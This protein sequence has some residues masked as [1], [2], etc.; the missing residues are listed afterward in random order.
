[1]SAD[2]SSIRSGPGAPAGAPAS[3]PLLALGL[4]LAAQILVSIAITTPSVLAPAVAPLLG[5]PAGRIGL[6]IGTCYLFAMLSG[7][8]LGGRIPSL[9][10][11]RITQIALACAA[12]GLWAGASGHL[13]LLAGAALGIGFAYGL[14]NP[15]ASVILAE[16]SPP[17][18]RGLFFSIKQTAVPIGVALTGLVVPALFLAF[19]WRAAT[20]AAGGACAL[21][22]LALQFGR[23]V[24]DAQA[25]ASRRRS[26]PS[27]LAS[28]RKAWRLLSEPLRIVIDERALRRLALVSL[29]FAMTQV[30]FLTFLVSYLKIAHG[31]T[32][33][34]AAGVLTSAQVVSVFARVAWGHVAD[35]WVTPSRLL[36]FLAFAMSA[37]CVGLGLLP[38]PSPVIAAFAA[39]IACGLTAVGWNGVFFAE[40]V[41]VAPADKLGAAT[42]A[43]QFLTF[44][45]GMIGPVAFG[46]SVDAGLGYGAAFMVL[47]GLPALTGV[48]L[49]RAPGARPVFQQPAKDRA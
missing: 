13:P 46:Q 10:P 31:Y 40:L 34:A 43:S 2:S 48:A 26:S 49:L 35:R 21:G 29:A 7:L 1:M 18:R 16:H 19:G 44:F 23:R 11:V 20:I 24:F 33:T 42:G 36:T 39:A 14:T 30:C 45:G 15:A 41:R 27:G 25:I 4:T 12:V 5:V 38:S 8:L 37:A 3:R 32:L 28:A 6:F 17:A 22:V 47:A 9:G